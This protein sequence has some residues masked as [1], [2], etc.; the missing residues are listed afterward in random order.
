M[1]WIVAGF[2]PVLRVL[3]PPLR[4]GR[5]ERVRRIPLCLRDD[6]LMLAGVALPLVDDL[7][8]KYPVVQ[9]LVDG[10]FAERLPGG[11][12]LKRE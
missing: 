10:L 2:V 11:G 6:G 4:I 5:D 12:S 8:P 9:H 1:L 7:A 3:P